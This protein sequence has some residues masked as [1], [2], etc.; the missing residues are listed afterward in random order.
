MPLLGREII[1]KTYPTT[2]YITA[3]GRIIDILNLDREDIELEH[4]A[5][6]LALKTRFNGSC[7]VPYSVAQHCCLAA[8]LTIPET[9]RNQKIALLHDAAEAYTADAP[10]CIKHLKEYQPLVKLEDEIQFAIYRKYMGTETIGWTLNE[11]KVLYN[12]IDSELLNHEA[13]AL[14]NNWEALECCKGLPLRNISIEPWLWEEAERTFLTI[15]ELL[16]IKDG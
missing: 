15:A 10:R 5:H 6:S 2:E 7:K 4:I 8:S 9:P 14:C 16:G 3:T 11:Y 13:R 1:M 12:P